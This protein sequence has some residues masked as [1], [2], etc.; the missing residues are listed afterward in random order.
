MF[1]IKDV[2]IIFFIYPISPS[3][4]ATHLSPTTLGFCFKRWTVPFDSSAHFFVATLELIHVVFEPRKFKKCF[5]T[6][7]YSNLWKLWCTLVNRNLAEEKKTGLIEWLG[8][9]QIIAFETCFPFP[10]TEP[11]TSYSLKIYTNFKIFF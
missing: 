4:H 3:L 11:Q 1:W 7:N 9:T 5:Y 2:I 10:Y 6:L 8:G